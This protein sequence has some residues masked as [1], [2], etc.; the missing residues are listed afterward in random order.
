MQVWIFYTLSTIL[1][2]AIL[3][4]MVRLIGS[5]Q[6]TQL[7]FFNWVAGAAMGNLAANM[8]ASKSAS[9]WAQS[10]YTLIL[11]SIVSILATLLALR[12]RPFRRIANGE[13]V[14]LIHKG[15][16]FRENLRK[17]KVNLDV[18]MMLLREK[19]YFSYSDIEFAILEPTGNLSILPKEESQ[20]VSKIDLVQGVKLSEKGQGPYVEIVIDGE[21]DND[22]LIS[23]GHDKA[24]LDEQI[25]KLGGKTLADVF[26]LAVN[27]Q[28]EII[29]DFHRRHVPK[30]PEI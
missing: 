24:W 22:K 26:Y 25:K 20:S 27:K 23:T 5:T 2:F 19:G 17:T 11:F 4:T 12:F 1:T 10:C 18:L 9:D 3:L 29:V 13:P 7:T 14:V 30:N 8:I 16:M 28:G 15:I 6:L 21:I